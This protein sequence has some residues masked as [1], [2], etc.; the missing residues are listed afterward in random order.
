MNIGEGGKLL[1]S[2]KREL[3][4]DPVKAALGWSPSDLEVLCDHWGFKEYWLDQQ[5]KLR[6]HPNYPHIE[7]VIPKLQD[8]VGGKKLAEA[9]SCIERLQKQMFHDA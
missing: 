2:M 4:D 6:Y 1:A 3:A 5:A 8:P 7:L 9:I